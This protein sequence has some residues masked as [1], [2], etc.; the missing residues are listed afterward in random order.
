MLPMV[1]LDLFGLHVFSVGSQGSMGIKSDPMRINPRDL[2]VV[3][4]LFDPS[5]WVLQI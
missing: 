1:V 2:E 5:W 4:E 3:Q